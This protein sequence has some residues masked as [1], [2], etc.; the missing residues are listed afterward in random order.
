MEPISFAASLSLVAALLSSSKD[1]KATHAMLNQCQCQLQVLRNHVTFGRV[2]NAVR[3]STPH[4][5]D[6][7]AITKTTIFWKYLSYRMPIGLLKVRLQESRQDKGSARSTPHVYTEPDIA[8]RF[9]PPRWLSGVAIDYSIKLSY[10]LISDQWPWSATLDPLTVNYNPFFINA[11]MSL[12]MEGVRR[13]FVERLA[14]RT[15]YIL[16][17]RSQPRPWY[18]VRLHFISNSDMLSWSC[19]ICLQTN[20]SGPKKSFSLDM[21]RYSY[22]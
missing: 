16:G 2:G 11:V 9:L 13:S 5:R 21:V 10:D 8:I 12:D 6:S 22:I 17:P 14:R 15:D 4:A 1:H 7:N 3:L 18:K 19:S 20:T